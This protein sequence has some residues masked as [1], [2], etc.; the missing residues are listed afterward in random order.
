MSGYRSY[1]ALRHVEMRRESKKG[2]RRGKFIWRISKGKWGMYRSC[3]LMDDLNSR[4]TILM[5]TGQ[6]KMRTDLNSENGLGF[7]FK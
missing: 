1:H 5:V 6:G 2:L 3:F 7:K 4:N